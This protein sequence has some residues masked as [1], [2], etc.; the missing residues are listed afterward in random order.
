MKKGHLIILIILLSKLSFSQNCSCADNFVW[1]KETFEKNDAGFQYVLDKKGEVDYKKHTDIYSEKVKTITDKELCAK[2]LLEWLRYF[3]RGHLW[4]KS[5]AKAEVSEKENVDNDKIR[6]QFKDWEKYAYNEKEFNSYISQLKKPTLEGIWSSPPYKIGIRKVNDE[7]I[8]FVLE[9]DGVY[10]T[11]A[12]VK[13]RIKDDN[14][15]ISG[16]YYM[17]DHSASEIKTAKFLGN[18]YFSLG[19]SLFKRIAPIFPAD[20]SLDLSF[21]FESTEIP[22]FEKLSNTTVILRIPSFDG[23]AKKQI[24]SIIVANMETITKT[25]NLIIDLQDNG[26]GSDG[27]FEKLIPLIYTNPIRVVGMELLSTPLNNKRMEEFANNPDASPEDKKWARE[28]ADKL[29]KNLGKF[30]NLDSSIVDIETS[31]TMYAYPKKVGIIINGGC[32]STTEQFILAAKQSKKVKLFGTTTFGSL[33]ISNMFSVKSPCND[34]ELGYCLSKSYRIP[35]FTI[36]GKGLQ[37]DY[38]IDKEIPNY[39]WIEY[40]NQILNTP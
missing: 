40:V 14:S 12:Q 16:T 5:L 30:V 36:D 33:D 28:T 22:L 20:K 32:G 25:E 1:L 6:K 23:S 27:S 4:L 15:K 39:G 17:R 24:D 18:N 19:S 2:A 29:N 34:L 31:D 37:P 3:R 11:K 38:Y 35:D 10:W 9:A 8:G 7:Y 13:F 26:G 21:K